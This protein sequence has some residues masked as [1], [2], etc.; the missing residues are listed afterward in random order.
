MTAVRILLPYPVENNRELCTPAGPFPRQAE[1]VTVILAM[2]TR[3][4]QFSDIR[5]IYIL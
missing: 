1:H 5:N 3:D 2:R 4:T